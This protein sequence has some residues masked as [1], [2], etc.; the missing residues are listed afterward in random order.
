MLP[1]C[2]PTAAVEIIDPS[3]LKPG[4]EGYFLTEIE[5]GEIYSSPIRV[6]GLLNGVIPEGET[7]LIRLLDPRF[8]K[9][10][11]AAGMSGSPVYVRG[12]L[13]G[14]L[15]FAWSFAS[16]PIAGVTPFERMAGDIPDESE[17][18]ERG[19]PAIAEAFSELSEAIRDQSLPSF[20]LD[21]QF[22][23]G[24][25]IGRLPISG[26]LSGYPGGFRVEGWLK[27]AMEG[28]GW[29][30][31]PAGGGGG[32]GEMG[33]VLQ[34]GSMIAAVLVDGDAHLAAGGTVTEIRGNRIWA[35]GHPFLGVGPVRLPM[36]RASV[37]TIL[38][39]L[40]NSFK[41][42]NTG[43]EIGAFSSDRRHGI[44]GTTGSK[45]RMI[46]VHLDL[47]GESFDFRIMPHPVLTPILGA[48]VVQSI[49]A[50]R[51][52]ALRNQSVKVDL[53]M[54]FEDETR[55]SLEQVFEGIDASAQSSA[56]ISA[57][58]A[59]VCGSSFKAPKLAR[60]SCNLRVRKGLR[61]LQILEVRPY[62][63]KLH[64]GEEFFLQ[65]NLMEPGGE[66]I[67]REIFLRVPESASRGRL[68]I[69]LA[70]GASFAAYDIKARPMET[71]SFS[72]Q[73]DLLRRL[74]SSRKIVAAFEVPG[75]SL[76]SS[77]GS[78]PLPAGVLA[79]LRSA[80]G[81]RLRTAGRR[82]A[83]LHTLE[84]DAPTL[85]AFRLQLEIVGEALK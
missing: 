39:S 60:L 72:D 32:S 65:L 42:F 9:T 16:E 71:H 24:G 85:G 84:L 6:L 47:N 49:Q 44:F 14:A 77:R 59:Y 66:K 19:G 82:I 35:F 11:V 61:R 37:V 56:W 1:I 58:T 40:A 17:K 83:G 18:G 34:P 50:I 69:V 29:M 12:K 7:V 41:I 55:V 74:E 79:N 57:L 46:P 45:A 36:A 80:R 30:A 13:V 33:T 5:G 43:A 26:G 75:K 67:R 51:S 73:L 10:G 28:M 68:D 38:P 8:E 76:I 20:M 2:F 54:G 4:E 31:I 62:K 27:K 70:D 21:H 53:E 22:S 3:D 52:P 81:A 64:P 23:G 15:A 25:S 48:Y 78:L 63:S